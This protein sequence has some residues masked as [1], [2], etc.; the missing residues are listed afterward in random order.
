MLK[1]KNGSVSV[2][3]PLEPLWSLLFLEA[4][5]VSWSAAPGMLEHEVH[6][7]IIQH[8]GVMLMSVAHVT[9]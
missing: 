6:V 4:M 7:D 1:M 5:L 9:M 2:L 3:E 8:P